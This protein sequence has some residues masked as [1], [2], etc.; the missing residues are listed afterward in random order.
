[1]ISGDAVVKPMSVV[2]QSRTRCRAVEDQ[3]A[4]PGT[5]GMP[6]VPTTATTCACSSEPPAGHGGHTAE[7]PDTQSVVG[8][9]A[10]QQVP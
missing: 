3:G 8:S 1:M 9:W 5:P 6:R 7:E 10:S 4:R 2:S